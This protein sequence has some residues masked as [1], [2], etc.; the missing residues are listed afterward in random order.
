MA[1]LER[2]IAGME[3]DTL[4]G[5]TAFE[6]YDSH[7]FPFELC[8]EICAERD[9]KVDREGF[10]R[11]MEAQRAR[12]RE[13]SS[14]GG[15]V[16]VATA[17][18]AI[19]KEVEATEFVGYAETE[20]ESEIAVVI[21]GEEPVDRI[22]P[23]D[24]PTRIL[25]R[26]TPFYAESGGQVGDTGVIEGPDGLFR[27]ADTKRVEDYIVHYGSVERGALARGDKVRLAVDGGRRAAIPAQPYGDP[28][29]PRGAS[30]HPR[31]A[32]GA[33]G[34][35]GRPRAA[36]L[37]LHPPAGGEGRRAGRHRG[38]GQRRDPAQLRRRNRVDGPRGGPRRRGDGALR[39]EVQRPGPRRH[40]RRALD[41]AL[42]RHPRPHLRRDRR[43]AC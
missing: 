23:E 6:L 13:G 39:R 36:P 9:L 16:F 33:G 34:L 31:Q 18:S 28:S 35:A 21:R 42:R 41:G 24:G 29:P 25:V 19:K 12:S 4:A 10:E 8:E 2:A 20:A 7:G 15:E 1:L 22:A 32:R 38:L 26:A 40:R 14:M 3:G 27:V 11:C 30:N 17:I 5:E 43:L 37:R